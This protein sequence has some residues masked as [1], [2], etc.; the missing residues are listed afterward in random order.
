MRRHQDARISAYKA[1]EMS[2][3]QAH[4]LLIQAVDARVAPI[5]RIP[6]ILKE[7][8]APRHPEFAVAK[9]GWRLFNAF[10][11]GL[12]G[13]ALFELPRATQALHGL[14]DQACGVE[15]MN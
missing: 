11:E 7:W 13:S 6:G 9:D 1:T 4:D 2:D 15:L 12:K 5:T 10:T 14:M 8:R 3:A